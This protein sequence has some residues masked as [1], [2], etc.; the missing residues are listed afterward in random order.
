MRRRAGHRVFGRRIYLLAVLSAVLVAGVLLGLAAGFARER[1]PW[2][3]NWFWIC[4]LL[5][6]IGVLILIS[7]SRREGADSSRRDGGDGV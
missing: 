2:G 7:G 1:R 4:V 6:P 5:G 3:W